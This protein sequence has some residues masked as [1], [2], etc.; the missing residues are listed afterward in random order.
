MSYLS[1]VSAVQDQQ[2]KVQRLVLPLY[3]TGNAT[4]ASVAILAD[5]PEVLF[6]RTQGVDQITA[7]LGAADAVP[8]FGDSPVDAS[9]VFNILVKIGEPVKKVCSARLV[10][11]SGTIAGSPAQL[12]SLGTASGIVQLTAGGPSDKIVLSA[13]CTV[14]LA[15]A[16]LDACL[17][18]EYIVVE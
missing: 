8:T 12:V 1:K 5:C 10:K 6:L 17:E 18:I 2:L 16:D 11:R 14:S 9:G 15:A 13:D 3:I 7:A 4:P